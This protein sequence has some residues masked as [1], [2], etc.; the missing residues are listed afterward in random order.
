MIVP[1][2]GSRHLEGKRADESIISTVLRVE[3]SLIW[4]AADCRNKARSQL[5]SSTGFAFEL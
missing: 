5:G 2:S 3:L 4:I 1:P